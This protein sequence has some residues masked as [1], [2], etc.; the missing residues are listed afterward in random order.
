MYINKIIFLSSILHFALTWTDKINI[1]NQHRNEKRFDSNIRSFNCAPNSTFNTFA[2]K[3]QKLQ[4]S[5]WPPL[6]TFEKYSFPLISSFQP[7]SIPLKEQCSPLTILPP[8]SS[9]SSLSKLFSTTILPGPS[10]H[11]TSTTISTPPLTLLQPES[12]QLPSST[13]PLSPSLPKLPSNQSSPTIPSP[14]PP[15]PLPKLPSNQSSPTIPSPPPPPPPPLPKLPSNQSS[16][17]IPLPHPTPSKLK[18]SSSTD[19]FLQSKQLQSQQSFKSKQ[20]T[21]SS[22]SSPL[23]LSQPQTSLSTTPSLL[24]EKPY[25]SVSPNQLN[26]ISTQP[27]TLNYEHNSSS[28]LQNS[29]SASAGIINTPKNKMKLIHW[30]KIKSQN[31]EK[32]L[33]SSITPPDISFDQN[34]IEELFIQKPKL[35]PK[36]IL[37]SGKPKVLVQNILD[38]KRSLAINIMLKQLKLETDKFI[39]DL[40]NEN[41]IPIEKLEIIQKILPI[42]DDVIAIKKYRGDPKNYGAAEKFCL[43]LNEIPCYEEKIKLMI[44]KEE[45]PSMLNEM[46]SLLR[47]IQRMCHDIIKDDSFK[48]FLSVVLFIGNHINAGTYAGNARSFT[49]NSLSK[50]YDIRTNKPR[51]TFLHF[52]IE[53]A[54]EYKDDILSFTKYSSSLGMLSKMSIVR[55]EEE[56]NT[57]NKQ[58]K[59]LLSK[60]ETKACT[61]NISESLK[62]FLEQSVIDVEELNDH[63]KI[64]IVDI[65][66]VAIYFGEDLTK[67]KIEECFGLLGNFFTQIKDIIKESERKQEK[68]KKKNITK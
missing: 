60:Y 26:T 31:L 39:N 3:N 36:I 55:L 28:M 44:L 63:Y 51:I 22:H 48:E 23:I 7:T 61:N 47:H 56:V 45:L 68:D 12:Q 59:S 8:T 65:Q 43:A 25:S 17:T 58:I 50:L 54:Q 1:F 13:T 24:H 38:N 19:Q 42:H 10:S 67:F 33:W 53:V 6:Q 62:K 52:V 15:P 21:E 20:S 37:N 11:L 14:P 46:H 29:K 16:Q 32:S 40:E 66:K 4:F 35:P 2:I 30:N 49:L 18:N 5:Q 64:A 9:S 57:S 41:Y 27:P 34:Q